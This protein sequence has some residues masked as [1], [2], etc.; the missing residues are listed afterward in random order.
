MYKLSSL[1]NLFAPAQ[2]A[3]EFSHTRSSFALPYQQN[4]ARDKSSSIFAGPN[5]VDKALSGREL[6]DP[7]LACI[8]PIEIDSQQV[9]CQ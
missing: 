4:R 3:H 9:G 6:I 7:V 1:L 5:Q 2:D 8:Q